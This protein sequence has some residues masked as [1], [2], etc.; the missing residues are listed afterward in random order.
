VRLFSSP[1]WRR[2]LAWI[3][4]AL[5]IV[6]AAVAIGVMYPSTRTPEAAP[7]GGQGYVYKAPKHIELTRAQRARVL[8]TAANFVSHAVARRKVEQA[9]DLTAPSLRGGL[10][11]AQWRS[12]TIPVVPFPVDEAR[13]KLDYSDVDAIGLQVLLFPRA[14]SGLRPELFNMELAA[15][16]RGAKQRFLVT[17]WAPSGLAGGGAPA[18]A[19]TG[20]GGVPNLSASFEGQARLGSH[21]LLVPL[22]LFAIVPLILIGFFARGWL[23]G[24]RAAAEFAASSPT[25]GLPPLRR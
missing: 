22:A 10:T 18:P 8:A 23:R 24:R 5:T 15:T 13:W 4:G 7:R 25:R 11:R 9:Y 3:I 20:A 2:R 17:S 1:R 12:G 14:G 21:W 19:A 16:G 6:G